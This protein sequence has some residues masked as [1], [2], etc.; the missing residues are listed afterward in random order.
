M[1]TTPTRSFAS[2]HP[3]LTP[4]FRTAHLTTPANENGA[5]TVDDK[6]LAHALRHFAQFGL[7]AAEE[8]YMR[9]DEALGEND[10]ETCEHW[11]EICRALD[12]RLARQFERALELSR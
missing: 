8:A 3:A 9:A 1:A 10:Q 4:L 7:G 5:P 11:L 2:A 6:V 12:R